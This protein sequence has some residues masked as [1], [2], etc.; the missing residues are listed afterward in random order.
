MTAAPSSTPAEPEL[1]STAAP[2]SSPRPRA[3]V[4]ECAGR[5]PPPSASGCSSGVPQ[6]HGTDVATAGTS[7]IGAPPPHPPPEPAVDAP[8]PCAEDPPPAPNPVP[9]QT[10]SPAGAVPAGSA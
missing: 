3:G 7:S 6:P 8:R 5:P 1:A 9:A 2:P 4:L 10:G